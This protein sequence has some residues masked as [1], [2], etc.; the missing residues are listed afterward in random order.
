MIDDTKELIC[1]INSKSNTFKS[2]KRN[3]LKKKSIGSLAS[4][5]LL[6]IKINIPSV[7]RWTVLKPILDLLQSPTIIAE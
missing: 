1:S 2:C 4:I 3:K 6:D 5:D 7:G